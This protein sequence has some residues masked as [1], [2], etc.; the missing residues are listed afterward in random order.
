MWFMIFDWDVYFRSTNKDWSCPNVHMRWNS[1]KIDDKTMEYGKH[2]ESI[3]IYIFQTIALLSCWLWG[4]LSSCQVQETGEMC[5]LS[6]LFFSAPPILSVQCSDQNKTL[7]ELGK[8]CADEILNQF[9]PHEIGHGLEGL[10]ICGEHIGALT[11]R[12]VR[13]KHKRCAFEKCDGKASDRRVTLEQSRRIYS[14][15]GAHVPVHSGLCWLH[16]KEFAGNREIKEG[17]LSGAELQTSSD[18]ERSTRGQ[19]RKRTQ[20]W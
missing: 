10:T 8:C 19:K 13:K 6:R 1:V 14:K 4:V 17:A 16:I 7:S 9:T 2:I 3:K 5:L 11:T 18:Q 12:N 15:S 20:E